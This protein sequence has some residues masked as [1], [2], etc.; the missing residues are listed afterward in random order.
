MFM[1]NQTIERIGIKLTVVL[2]SV[3]DSHVI[4]IA[5]DN[6]NRRLLLSCGS[7]TNGQL[8]LGYSNDYEHELKRV[9]IHDEIPVDASAGVNHSAIVTTNG[10]VYTFGSGHLFVLGHGDY[11]DHYEPCLVESLQDHHIIKVSCGLMH[12]AVIS[13]KNEVYHWGVSVDTIHNKKVSLILLL[14]LLLLLPLLLLI[15]ILLLLL[16]IQIIGLPISIDIPKEDNDDITMITSGSRHIALLTRNTSC[17]KVIV[18][19]Q[20]GIHDGDGDDDDSTASV[21]LNA[22]K[23]YET[24]PANVV[25]IVSSYYEL[26]I[27]LKS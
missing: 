15:L 7:N 17:D 9:I 16:L 4:V 19:G 13:D 5:N 3:G 24:T 12:T 20:I 14:I 27:L 11:D 10:N 21:N 8:G 25:S 6:S 1:Y 26:G 22:R 18:I 2:V 23:L